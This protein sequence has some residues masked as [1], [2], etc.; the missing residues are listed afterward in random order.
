MAAE[1]DEVL[2]VAAASALPARRGG[3]LVVVRA[4]HLLADEAAEVVNAAL[5]RLRAVGGT[6]AG[7]SSARGKCA[8][9][10]VV[11]STRVWVERV[12]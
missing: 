7:R 9:G 10:H 5:R 8:A 11:T 4:A 3:S 12:G 1:A 2:P 6:W